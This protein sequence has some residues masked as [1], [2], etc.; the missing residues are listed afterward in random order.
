ML[1]G[2]TID[3][4]NV[5]PSDSGK[6][7]NAC[8]VCRL[9]LLLVVA[10]TVVGLVARL[11]GLNFSL[12]YSTYADEP[13]VVQKAL[14]SGAILMGLK[15]DQRL[16]PQAYTLILLL[17]YGA[18]YLLGLAQGWFG[19]AT[20]LVA[21]F[22]ANPTTLILISRTVSALMGAAAIPLM[23]LAGARLFDR[24]TGF[25][26]AALLA[27]NYYLVY[28]GH[29]AVTESMLSM[30][31]T[32]ALLFIARLYRSKHWGNYVGAGLAIGLGIATKLTPAVLTLS[33]LAAHLLRQ[34]TSWRGIYHRLLDWRLWL[35]A[36]AVVI[37]V[38]VSWPG[39]LLNLRSFQQG[40][41]RD[42]IQ[43]I[44]PGPSNL[45]WLVVHK[46][47]YWG[48]TAAEPV[49]VNIQSLRLMGDWTLCLAL[50][51]VLY[52]LLVFPRRW[53]V[54]LSGPL[55]LYLYLGIS[56]YP[57]LRQISLVIP[58]LMLMEAAFVVD[59]ARRL[60]LSSSRARNAVL[61]VLCIAVL[62]Q[63]AAMVV[64]LDYLLARPGTL[65]VAAG[66]IMENIPP[67]SKIA[68][69][70]MYTPFHKFTAQ[71]L[72]AGDHSGTNL[73]RSALAESAPDYELISTVETEPSE[74]VNSLFS[75]LVGKKVEY[76]VV[77]DYYYYQFYYE[78]PPQAGTPERAKWEQR[79]ALYDDLEARATLVTAFE[80]RALQGVGPLIKIY[81]L[82]GEAGTP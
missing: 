20:D 36:V 55:A 23:Y 3:D 50:A 70:P 6:H 22:V 35:A 10:L 61:L 47:I 24:L 74:T 18:Y 63:P 8:R 15:P 27:S 7:T 78:D 39:L 41:G 66:W 82:G 71:A 81:R 51:G 28:Y 17:C 69:D 2:E 80:P 34:P 65:P 9:V 76:V 33:L 59:L 44:S 4:E 42:L 26:A 68:L 25:L 21:Q 16:Y 40:M 54:I 1:S 67:G 48:Q 64:R 46:P 37:G 30:T 31:G 12:P 11:W 13:V 77:A 73:L 75:R 56:N 58:F 53:L 79:R 32:L 14:Q 49:S 72:A 29:L 57:S 38:T 43:H 45:W 62:A 60:P 52:G 5:T 19:A